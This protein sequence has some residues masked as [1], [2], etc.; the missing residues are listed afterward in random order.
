MKKI[1][2]CCNAGM[3]TSL[4]VQKMQKE[5]ASRDLDVDIEA[6]P[7]NEAMDHVDEAAIILLGPQI[8]Y[9]KADFERAVEGRD[10]PVEVIPM[11]EYGRM[12]AAKILD[13]VQAKIG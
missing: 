8:G 4:L 7:L 2:L 6:R 13:D 11:I 9:T 5:A 12:N 10:I 1:L 3:S